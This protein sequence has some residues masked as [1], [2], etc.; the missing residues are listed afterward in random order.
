MKKKLI[1]ATA[2]VF[3]FLSL[4][5]VASA[6]E[7]NKGPDKDRM[8]TSTEAMRKD[9]GKHFGWLR[10]GFHAVVGTVSSIDGTNLTVTASSG[11]AFTVDASSTLVWKNGATSTLSSVQT[12]DQV[13]VKGAK[14]GTTTMNARFIIDGLSDFAKK[15]G[16]DI[17]GWF[18]FKG[19]G[20]NK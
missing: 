12:G 8:A 11:R 16:K 19:K 1:I 20:D 3:A 14:T 17:R 5:S 2:F 18:H 15:I 7:I 10:K 6:H 13:L 9:D 4:S